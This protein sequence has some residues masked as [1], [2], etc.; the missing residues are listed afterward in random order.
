MAKKLE[1]KKSKNDDK[2]FQYAITGALNYEQIKS[3]IK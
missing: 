2:C 3:W 1:N